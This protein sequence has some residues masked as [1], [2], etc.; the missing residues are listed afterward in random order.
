M[1]VHIRLF[2]ALRERAGRDRLELELPDG[3]RVADALAA[4]TTS[5]AACRS[6]WP[7][8]ASTREDQALHAGDEL[9]L[10]PPVWGRR[11]RAARRPGTHRALARH[12]RGRRAR[13]ARRRAW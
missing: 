12:A 7:S 3:A 4:V 6:C 10:I 9:A 5:L 8:I 11:D 1:V 2:A 13:S